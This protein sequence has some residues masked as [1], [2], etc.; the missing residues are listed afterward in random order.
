MFGLLTAIA[1]SFAGYA[2]SDVIN[3]RERFTMRANYELF[4]AN[5]IN[6]T[7]AICQIY[8]NT[9]SQNG[10][11]AELDSMCLNFIRKD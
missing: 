3:R 1:S 2:I 11:N 8:R 9:L 4:R 6:Q 5:S 7:K 10:R